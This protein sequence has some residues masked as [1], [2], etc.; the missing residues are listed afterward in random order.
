MKRLRGDRSGAAAVEFA[1]VLPLLMTLVFG[2]FEFGLLWNTYQVVTDAAREGA[3]RAVIAN[4]MYANSPDSVFG[5]VTSAVRRARP[6][7]QVVVN[8]PGYCDPALPTTPLANDEVEIYGCQWDAGSGIPA[9]VAVRYG[10]ELGVIGPLLN[11][12]TGQRSLVLSTDFWM[13][14]E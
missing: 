5:T 11:W 4:P 14:N 10:Y 7:A 8:D 13:R 9:R 2:V 3:R 1:L 6:G 12:T